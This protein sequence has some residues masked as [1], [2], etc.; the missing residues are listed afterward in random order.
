MIDY[1]IYHKARERAHDHNHRE[2]V[3]DYKPDNVGIYEKETAVKCLHS[4][5]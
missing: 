3:I 4:S 5:M 2:I 1:S